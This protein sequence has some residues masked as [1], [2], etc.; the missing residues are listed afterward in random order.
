MKM[1]SR[2]RRKWFGANF[3]RGYFRSQPLINPSGLVGFALPCAA[4][5]LVC[6]VL[7]GTHAFGSHAEPFML[8][9]P[10]G[11]VGVSQLGK[12]KID[13]AKQASDMLD[14][15]N[16]AG[17]FT[18]ETRKS[19]NELKLKIQA[20]NELLAEAEAQNAGAG[21][22]GNGPILEEA[23]EADRERL[24]NAG[25]DAERARVQTI[26]ETARALKLRQSFADQHIKLGTTIEVFRRLA[27]DQAG[28]EEEAR[29]QQE[30]IRGGAIATPAGD[31]R[32]QDE[33]DARRFGMVGA[34]LERFEPKGWSW[35]ER[36]HAYIFH[37]ERRQQLFEGARQYIGMSLM[38]VAKECLATVGIRWQAKSRTEIV[39]LAFQ[40]TSDFP[41]IL[42]D[43]ANKSLRAGY[44]MADS[45]WRLIAARRTA[46]D[47][48]TMYELTLDQS[49][50]L[51]KVKETGEFTRGALIE[52]RESYALS[53][54][55]KIIAITRQAII[56][57]DLGAFTRVP[58]LLGQEVAM[59][60]AD[61]VI[62]IIT[63]NGHLADGQDL[64][65][66]STYHKNYTSSGAAIAVDSI[67]A[68]RVKM[69]VQESTGGKMLG[70]VPRY[71]LAPA[72]KGQLAMQYCSPNYQA[73]ESAKIN[74]W[75]GQLT[76]IVE[77]RL[78]GTST[79]AWYLFAD[80]NTPNGTVLVYAYLE[81]Q[82][83]PYT[84][85][86]Q[87]FDVDGVEVKIRQ[88]FAAAAVD[89]RGAAKQAGA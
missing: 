44:E 71:L 77:S 21:S 76:P 42:A 7:V 16:A 18:D 19:Y 54:Y 67:G 47:F 1:N 33:A 2:D 53:T 88:D 56:N 28:V 48:K 84:E 79:T 14:A 13:L 55:G 75:A 22:G 81:G 38:D 6:L 68:L 37:K 43:S 83:G 11:L 31:P 70:I 4:I 69:M 29:R 41:Y 60:E 61:T 9:P 15:A 50:R 64:F 51:E 82:E 26:N 74:P 17:G 72:T 65:E 85:T 27:I 30:G 49:S 80:P 35:D 10:A 32:L 46:A 34:L 58:F 73:A 78:D 5:L 62:G 39:S 8:I 36:T 20:N 23:N 45:Q 12:N 86:R 57:D 40:S 59:L 63:A 66:E 89:Y 24:I 52:G 3:G 25:R 87:G